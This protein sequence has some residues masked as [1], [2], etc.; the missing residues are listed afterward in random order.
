MSRA[1][2]LLVLLCVSACTGSPVGDPCIPEVVPP[3][4]FD[5]RD[6]YVESPSVQCVTRTCV[7]SG[8]SGDPREGCTGDTCAS[9]ADVPRHVYC[10][11]R[12]DSEAQSGACACP[13]GFR[14]EPFPAQG[15]YCVRE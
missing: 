2:L 15:S 8:L 11:C 6:R 1:P 4:G 9:P 10:S 14:C 7:V 13:T 3:G 5:E 12:C